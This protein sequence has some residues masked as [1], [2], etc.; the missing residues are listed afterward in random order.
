[1]RCEGTTV[2]RARKPMIW[3]PPRTPPDYDYLFTESAWYVLGYFLYRRPPRHE[4]QLALELLRPCA[5]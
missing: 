4:R 5:L 3:F 1:L 2:L